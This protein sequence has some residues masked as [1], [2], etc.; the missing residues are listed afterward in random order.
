MISALFF[1]FFWG[2]YIQ[3]KRKKEIILGRGRG[4]G[5]EKVIYRQSFV[6]D[7][8][9]KREFWGYGAFVFLRPLDIDLT[10]GKAHR[11][12]KLCH[13]VRPAVE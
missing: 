3:P 4:R 8:I 2:R 7:D 13:I 11:S 10:L 5:R 1:F 9:F 12:R 6:L